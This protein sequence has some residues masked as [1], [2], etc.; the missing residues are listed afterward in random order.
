MSLTVTKNI[1]ERAE[2]YQNDQLSAFDL[3]PPQ[4]NCNLIFH[5]VDLIPNAKL[6]PEE[7][8]VDKTLLIFEGECVICYNGVKTT[9]IKGDAVW[10]EK[11]SVH[12]IENQNAPLTF[13]V[14]K[15]K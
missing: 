7:N 14:V 12:T 13:I 10:L 6:D 5:W 8:D 1:K 4:K 15:S 11:G 3:V 9:V 2:K